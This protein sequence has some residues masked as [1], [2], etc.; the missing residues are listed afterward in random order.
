M[1]VSE[2]HAALHRDL[3][4]KPL[5]P[6]WAKAEIFIGLLMTGASVV[7]LKDPH[8]PGEARLFLF[9]LGAYL[10]MAGHRSHLY[11]SNNKLIAY[12]IAKSSL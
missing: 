9:V 1:D 12:L 5:N 11:Q 7:D 3:K 4:L 10:A 2:A 8:I 6:L